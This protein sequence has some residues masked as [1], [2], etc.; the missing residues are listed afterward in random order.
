MAFFDVVFMLLMPCVLLAL[1]FGNKLVQCIALNILP[2]VNTSLLVYVFFQLYQYYQI[3]QLANYFGMAPTWNDI[4]QLAV[5][6]KLQSTQNTLQILL[7][8]IIG[9]T[10]WRSNMYA[11][12]AMLLLL[13]LPGCIALV[14]QTPYTFPLQLYK[15]PILLGLN[16]ISVYIGI[17]GLF[18]LTK[19]LSLQHANNS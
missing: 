18:L 1:V 5:N 6:N 7:P 3:Y 10:K 9:V 13:W 16:V 17:W 14:N 12:I 8:L 11:S 2:V 15:Q 4:W 19:T